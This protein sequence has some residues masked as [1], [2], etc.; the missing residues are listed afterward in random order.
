MSLSSFDLIP[1]LGLAISISVIINN[2]IN[3]AKKKIVL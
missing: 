3:I 2:K 1:P